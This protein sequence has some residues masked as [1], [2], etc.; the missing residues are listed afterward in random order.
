MGTHLS[1]RLAWNMNGWNGCICETPSANSYCVGNY[2]FPGTEIRDKRDLPWE[3]KNRGRP[4]GEV[5]GI[6]PCAS[7]L[8]C[9]R[10]NPGQVLQSLSCPSDQMQDLARYLSSRTTS[11]PT[12]KIQAEGSQGR[13]PS[14][15]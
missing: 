3:E 6:P 7:S 9:F 1:A 13:S 2:S 5:E 10:W 8:K 11:M 12:P 14:T 4:C 15:Q